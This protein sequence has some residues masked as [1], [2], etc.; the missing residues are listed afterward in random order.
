MVIVPSHGRKQKSCDTD[1]SHRLLRK[2]NYFITRLH[3]VRQERIEWRERERERERR[4][5]GNG[6]WEMAVK[7]NTRRIRERTAH[8]FR[9]L[10]VRST[11]TK[12][13]AC[14]EADKIRLRPLL[15]GR[16]YA[17]QTSGET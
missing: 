6:K 7:E 2:C 5:M 13:T 8:P 15:A 14:W 12:W 4:E 16:A 3:Q 9:R 11:G 10:D 17:N 1:H